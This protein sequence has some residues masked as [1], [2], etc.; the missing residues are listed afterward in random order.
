M[1][2]WSSTSVIIQT[3]HQNWDKMGSQYLRNCWSLG[4]FH[5]QASLGIAEIV[6]NNRKHPVSSSS[7]GENALVMRGLRRTTSLLQADRKATVSKLYNTL[8][9]AEVNLWIYLESNLRW[10]ATAANHHSRLYLCQCIGFGRVW[11]WHQL[12]IHAFVLPCLSRS[13]L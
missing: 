9:Y 5:A 7:V 11:I 8:L 4:I 13:G 6:A 2:T 1:Y 10:W 12:W 3:K